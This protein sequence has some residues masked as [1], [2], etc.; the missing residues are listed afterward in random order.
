M[1]S[2]SLQSFYT[3]IQCSKLSLPFH[4]NYTIRNHSATLDYDDYYRLTDNDLR[5]FSSIPIRRINSD[6]SK[7]SKC[8]IH[9]ENMKQSVMDNFIDPIMAPDVPSVYNTPTNIS[10]SHCNNAVE[11]YRENSIEKKPIRGRIHTQSTL[12]RRRNR[13]KHGVSIIEKKTRFIFDEILF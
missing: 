2:L 8:F 6:P 3:C 13:R 1:T 7:F 11:T 4:R 10:R 5:K 12:R 9:S